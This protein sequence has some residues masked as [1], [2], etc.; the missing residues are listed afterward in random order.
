MNYDLR[1]IA[2]QFDIEG[3]FVSAVPYGTGHINDTFRSIFSNGVERHFIH[4][5]INHKIFTEP[6]KLMDNISR[7]T[8]HLRKKIVAAGGNP[9]RQ[10]LTLVPT[11]DGRNFCIMDGNYW[12][13]YVFIEGAKTYDLVEKPQH[14]F[15]AAWAFGN[16][17][18]L[19]SDL[20]QPR[21]HDTIPDFHNTIRR[22]EQ[23]ETALNGDIASRAAGCKPEIDFAMARREMAGVIV[24]ALKNG[25]IPE[26]VTH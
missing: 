17:Q 10:C 24:N 19:V 18:K 16:F 11:K 13:T 25:E 7:V 26:R 1:K 9:M 4:Q 15:N 21:L 22:F 8:K 12:R 2:E 5:R 14:I 3:K 20:T 6:E 23:F